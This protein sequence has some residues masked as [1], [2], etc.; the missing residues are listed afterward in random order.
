MLV[1]GLAL[2]K[3]FARDFAF[4]G[5]EGVTRIVA[6]FWLGKKVGVI[7]FDALMSMIL[8]CAFV[9]LPFGVMMGDV[10]ELKPGMVAEAFPREI[11]RVKVTFGEDRFI[12][13]GNRGV[14]IVALFIQKFAGVA[15]RRCWQ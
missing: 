13:L 10:A 12:N 4:F 7:H 14:F 6:W 15:T 9:T 8:D 2:K 11:Q 1:E 3:Q 5:R